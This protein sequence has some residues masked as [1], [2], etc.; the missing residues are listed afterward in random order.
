MSDNQFILSIDQGTTSSR[1]VLFD[2]E[3]N[4]IAQFQEE[5]PQ[6]FPN[7]G[8]VEQK[9]DEIWQ[10]VVN[11]VRA[12]NEYAD[13]KQAVISGL[14]ITNQR[15]TT[16]IWD[17]TTGNAIHNA[18]V[19]QDR[20]TSPFCQSLKQDGLSELINSKTGLVLD[21]YFSA[22]K[23]R[24]ILNNVDGARESAEQGRLAF[25]T[26]ESFL[27]W[28]L[29]NGKAHITDTTNA[30]RTSLFNINTLQWDDELLNIFSIPKSLLP[31]V[32]GCTPQDVLTDCDLFAHAVPVLAIAGDQQAAAI[33]QQ[34]FQTGESKST[35]GTGCFLTVNTGDNVVLSKNN[36]LST[37][38]FT[39]D[40]NTKYALEGSIFMAGA[41]VQWLR[42][43]LGIISHAADT[44]ALAASLEDNQG[45]YLVP[46]FTG[47]GAPYWDA[48]ARAA[49]VGLTRGS[50]KAAIARAALE[51]VCYQTQDLLTAIE[52]DGVKINSLNID[53]GMVA[54]D[55]LCQCLANILALNIERPKMQEST[56][57]GVANLCALQ[58]GI[59]RDLQG[60][61]D[62]KSSRQR[63]TPKLPAAKREQC[64]GGWRAAVNMVL[65]AEQ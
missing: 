63:F 22:S 35:Y 23:I 18:I 38:A 27:I 14:G 59:C 43:Q 9:P 57:L 21:P 13:S 44:E 11:V 61:A 39:H 7:D 3:L 47:L 19:W 33:G 52:S 29:T 8:W 56:A 17:K 28:R 31:E 4:L 40:G 37:V 20:R 2:V 36:L 55:W 1:A 51:S 32:V 41:T 58:L 60:L 53:G 34:C 64:L 45:V 26:V 65:T 30:S 5:F 12:A 49:I 16:I 48:A 54:N 62:F 25:G 15:E 24:W 6:Y 46:A 42:D 50:G 10:S